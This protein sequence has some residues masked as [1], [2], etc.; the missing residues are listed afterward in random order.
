MYYFSSAGKG[1]VNVIIVDGDYERSSSSVE[2]ESMPMIS[3]NPT[4]LSPIPTN[5]AKQK[6]VEPVIKPIVSPVH[7][8]KPIT[9]SKTESV[10]TDNIDVT[11]NRIW[12]RIELTK[13]N[14][15]CIPALRKKFET[16]RPWLLGTKASPKVSPKLSP[17]IEESVIKEDKQSTQVDSST[18]IPKETKSEVP[19]EV[20]S[21]FTKEVRSDVKK[22]PPTEEFHCDRK[23]KSKKRKRRNSSSS[24]SSHS[25]ISNLSQSGGRHTK[26]V[27]KEVEDSKSKR[28]KDD[29]ESRSQTENLNLT[30]TPPTNHEREASRTHVSKNS[31]PTSPTSKSR[32]SRQYRSYFE[33]P[34][35]PPD[36]KKRLAI[37]YKLGY[38]L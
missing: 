9:P 12:V 6:S 7:N 17:K 38:S 14:I 22:P 16:S 20:R 29:S 1:G 21:E 15:H 36:L 3:S 24:I 2:D 28:R 27:S 23:H 13:L 32:S 31:D 37:I 33:P 10:M 30:T 25:T 34:D 5:E 11:Q 35:E 4:L 19:K 26:N 8:I 18:K